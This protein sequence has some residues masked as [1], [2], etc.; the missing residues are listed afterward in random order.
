MGL[1]SIV[2][3]TWLN[4]G[5]RITV[6]T[7]ILDVEI[8]V[9]HPIRDSA[10]VPKKGGMNLMNSEI[11]YRFDLPLKKRL[12]HFGQAQFLIPHFLKIDQFNN[13]I[14]CVNFSHITFERSDHTH[15]ST[16]GFI[17]EDPELSTIDFVKFV[18]SI[19]HHPAEMTKIIFSRCQMTSAALENRCETWVISLCFRTFPS[20]SICNVKS[21]ARFSQA[22]LIELS[23]AAAGAASYILRFVKMQYPNQRNDATFLFA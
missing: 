12:F 4:R 16:S 19:N 9:C 15:F 1:F 18:E 17:F 8:H 7:S 3:E 6:V 13:S 23:L 5:M 21:G 11:Q 10:T 14:N 2:L 22:V 20:L